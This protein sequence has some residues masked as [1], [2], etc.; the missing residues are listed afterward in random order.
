M[1]LAPTFRLIVGLFCLALLANCPVNPV[2]GRQNFVTMSESDAFTLPGDYIHTT[3]GIMAYL[4]SEAELAA[5]YN[6]YRESMSV[7]IAGGFHALQ[8]AE[9]KLAKPTLVHAYPAGAASVGT[10]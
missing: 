2:T 5:I 4:N 10:V 8:D 6:R 1:K 7:S 9:R 3:R